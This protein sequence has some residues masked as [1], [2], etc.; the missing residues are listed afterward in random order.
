MKPTVPKND[1]CDG[2]T[3]TTGIFSGPLAPR[4]RRGD[5]RDADRPGGPGGGVRHREGAGKGLRRPAGRRGAD[6]VLGAVPRLP[7][8]PRA[9]VELSAASL[10]LG[11]E[12]DTGRCP[13]GP[14]TPTTRATW[15]A[16]A[17]LPPPESLPQRSR[18][19]LPRR[20]VPRGEGLQGEPLQPSTQVR[21]P[22]RQ[23]V[24]TRW[25]RRGGHEDLRN[26]RGDAP[27]K[28]PGADG[29]G[30]LDGG[31]GDGPGGT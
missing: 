3:P 28:G 19:R 4:S 20:R 7:H 22:D 16:A 9:R 11:V 31:R 14:R 25:T 29:T 8:V 27:G 13:W 6:G 30:V 18:G 21:K 2:A 24:S 5:R 23:G 1:W 26:G 10:S 12:V 15:Y 17:R